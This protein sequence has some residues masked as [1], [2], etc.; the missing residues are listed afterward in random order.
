M[1]E[2]MVQNEPD[3]QEEAHPFICSATC[4]PLALTAC[5]IRKK[6]SVKDPVFRL[7]GKRRVNPIFILLIRKEAGLLCHIEFIQ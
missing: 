2:D 3:V 4:T 7:D 1:D 6:L 5:A